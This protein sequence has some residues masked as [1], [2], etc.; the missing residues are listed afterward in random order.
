MADAICTIDISDVAK[1]GSV[2]EAIFAWAKESDSVVSAVVGSSFSTSGPGNGWT[3]EHTTSNYAV[4]ALSEGATA[5]VNEVN[6]RVLESFHPTEVDD[7][8]REIMTDCQ[9]CEYVQGEWSEL[10][11]VRLECPDEEDAI[12]NPAAFAQML[13]GVIDYHAP[14]SDLAAWKK[15]AIAIMECADQIADLVEEMD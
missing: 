10:S 3:I 7:E 1:A 11:M 15:L 8:E 13:Q 5:Y 9:G 12:A 2:S 4:R 6:G 14:C